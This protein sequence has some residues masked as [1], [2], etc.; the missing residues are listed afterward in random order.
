MIDRP[1]SDD[2]REA[3]TDAHRAYVMAATDGMYL[4]GPLLSDDG[5]MMVGSLII[6]EFTGRAEAQAFVDAEPYN[7]AGLF[8][9][10]TIRRYGPV[11][12]PAGAS[13]P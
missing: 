12:L 3:T 13:R 7:V 1:H 11:V 5:E 8:E 10:V 9:S 2:L 6:K 4:G